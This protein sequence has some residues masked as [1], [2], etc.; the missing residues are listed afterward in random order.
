VG[1]ATAISV[2]PFLRP[3][4]KTLGAAVFIFPFLALAIAWIGAWHLAAENERLSVVMA[5]Y[6]QLRKHLKPPWPYAGIKRSWYQQAI[7]ESVGNTVTFL[8]VVGF[9]AFAMVDALF[10]LILLNPE[11]WQVPFAIGTFILIG[12][13]LVF[14]LRVNGRKARNNQAVTAP[15]PR[16]QSRAA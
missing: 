3:E 12:V 1:A 2:A 8:F 5:K 11:D 10:L 15:K 14:F 9:T 13:A 7:T 6:N 16:R 4:L